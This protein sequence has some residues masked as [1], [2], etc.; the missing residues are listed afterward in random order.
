MSLVALAG[1][2]SNLLLAV[3]F[4]LLYKVLVQTGW[5]NGAAESV[6]E[7]RQDLLPSVMRGAMSFNLILTVFNL[8]PIPPLDGSRVMAWLLPDT[9]RPTYLGIERFGLVII[10]FL[11][12]GSSG[13]KSMMSSTVGTLSSWIWNLITL[14][15]AW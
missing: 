7:R 10:A 13:F 1:P 4:A 5:Y 11:A 9:L 12:F 2:M 3:L 14:G 8:V 6:F 15:G